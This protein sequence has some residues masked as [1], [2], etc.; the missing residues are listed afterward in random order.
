MTRIFNTLTGFLMI[1]V[2]AIILVLGTA[3]IWITVIGSVFGAV[4]L[5][6]VAGFVC[7]M[8]TFCD[9]VGDLWLRRRS[10]L[11]KKVRGRSKSHDPR[12]NRPR[13]G[14]L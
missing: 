2:V 6:L 4:V 5:F 7:G 9:W 14:T 11:L 12:T 10:R 1:V 3:F 13:R 8:F